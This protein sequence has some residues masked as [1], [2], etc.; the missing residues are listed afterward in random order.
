MR[1][2][3]LYNLARM[4]DILRVRDELNLSLP[5]QADVFNLRYLHGRSL[6]QIGDELNLA[7]ST[8]SHITSQINAKLAAI[9]WPL[10]DPEV[11]RQRDKEARKKGKKKAKNRQ[12]G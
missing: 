10:E 1:S 4:A 8:V 12:G 3:D 11:A 2:R 9:S 7:Y 6:P 5:H